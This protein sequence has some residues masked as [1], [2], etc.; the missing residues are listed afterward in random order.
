MI[1][2]SSTGLEVAPPTIFPMPATLPLIAWEAL[3]TLP[4]NL[5]DFLAFWM[6]AL[7]LSL[8]T[9]ILSSFLTICSLRFL[10][11]DL[12]AVLKRDGFL[13]ATLAESLRFC[14]VTLSSLDCS[15]NLL[16]LASFSAAVA[17]VS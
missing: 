8:L 11:T 17:S 10:T 12:T 15:T 7:K 1:A 13:T 9:L 5:A 4:A 3:A 16:N 14:L 6:S 2:I